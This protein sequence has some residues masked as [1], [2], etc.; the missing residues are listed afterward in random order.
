V[1]WTISFQGDVEVVCL[2]AALAATK[3]HAIG[4]SRSRT[5][6]PIILKSNAIEV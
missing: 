2:A 3:A 6:P 5:R 4:I 1:H